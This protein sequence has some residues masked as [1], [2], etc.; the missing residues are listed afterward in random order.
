M[1]PF[2]T[3]TSP[4]AHALSGSRVAVSKSMAVNVGAWFAA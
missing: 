2:S 3:R 1:T 4:I